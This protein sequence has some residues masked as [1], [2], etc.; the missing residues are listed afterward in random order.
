M[1]SDDMCHQLNYVL[2]LFTF[3]IAAKSNTG[4]AIA[5]AWPAGLL[6][7]AGFC[8]LPAGGEWDESEF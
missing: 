3:A 1:S 4:A 2:A 7:A 6:T 8:L 5:I